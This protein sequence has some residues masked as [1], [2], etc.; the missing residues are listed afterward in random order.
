MG[1]R[2]WFV[3]FTNNLKVKNTGSISNRYKAITRRI[4]SDFWS[5]FSEIEHSRYVGSYG[6]NTAIEGFSDLDMIF[7][8]PYG[9]Y[10][11]Y[12]QYRNNGQSS[13]L[14]SVKKSIEKTY[15]TTNIR[16]DGQVI[17]VPFTDG[18]TY[19]IVPGFINKNNS[20]TYPDANNGGKWRVTNPIPEIE[21]IRARNEA[22][23][24]NLVFLC[25]MMRAWKRK[26]Q[27]PVSG[28]LVDTFAYQ[29]FEDYEYRKQSFIYYD[30]ICRDFFL[31]MSE[32]SRVQEYWRA[33][34]SGQ[35]VYGK[36]L[37]Q[38]KAKRCYNLAK[39]AIEHETATPKREWSAKQK[40]KEIFG[41][42]F[43]G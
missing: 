41:K 43:P 5:T 12:N 31:W 3:M 27:V 25:R 17:Q 1:L 19:E 23:N 37:F 28:L 34:G 14:Q 38:Y 33:P 32:Q 21:A 26:W 16:A 15:S 24:R 9:V 39:E 8:L 4:N 11:Q 29:F 36:G 30:F 42:R 18:L 20:Y 10:V 6:R 35:R 7:R 2:D 40:W 13:L 22:C